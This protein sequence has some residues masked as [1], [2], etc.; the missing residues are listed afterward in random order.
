MLRTPR[1]KLL[2]MYSFLLL[3]SVYFFAIHWTHTHI[4]FSLFLTFWVTLTMTWNV[5]LAYMLFEH[6]NCLMFRLL[7]SVFLSKLILKL[8]TIIQSDIAI[9]RF[10]GEKAET[11]KSNILTHFWKQ[12]EELFGMKTALYSEV[13]MYLLWYFKFVVI[14][15]SSS[16][17]LLLQIVNWLMADN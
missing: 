8:F 10:L 7:E 3:D 14:A 1:S 6:K 4:M 11:T 5:V 13:E 9:T 12:M 15:I 17:S 16:Y 2:I